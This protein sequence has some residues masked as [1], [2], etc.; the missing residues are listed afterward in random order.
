MR[1]R[2]RLIEVIK[3]VNPSLYPYESGRL[4]SAAIELD[5][6]FY[7]DALLE[8]LQDIASYHKS[9]H[10]RELATEATMYWGVKP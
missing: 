7:T 9:P 4:A 1:D 3:T 2:K 8:D 10:I 6:G 5:T